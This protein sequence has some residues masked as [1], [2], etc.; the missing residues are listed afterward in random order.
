MFVCCLL[1]V[2]LLFF[3]FGVFVSV[4]AVFE[5]LFLFPFCFVVVV[6]AYCSGGGLARV[7]EHLG[8][9]GAAGHI[10][11]HQE[12][13]GAHVGRRLSMRELAGACGPD[14]QTQDPFRRGLRLVSPEPEERG[15]VPSSSVPTP[16]SSYHPTPV[17]HILPLSLTP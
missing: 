14:V 8:N 10:P 12:G 6:G 17:S 15:R 13:L 3:V 4:F 11:L 16:V 1:R 5:R 7:V 9:D 2:C